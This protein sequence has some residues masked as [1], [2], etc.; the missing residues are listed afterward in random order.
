MRKKKQ[1][2]SLPNHD[3]INFSYVE[4]LYQ[5]HQQPFEVSA[6]YKVK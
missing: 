5:M 3:W 1:F 4:P 2:L 6:H